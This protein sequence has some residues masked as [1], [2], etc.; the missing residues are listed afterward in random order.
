MARVVKV[1]NHDDRESRVKELNDSVRSD[2]SR[3]AG[4]KNTFSHL[5][6]VSSLGVAEPVGQEDD[7]P[8][9]ITGETLSTEGSSKMV[10]ENEEQVIN[11]SKVC[12]MASSS[13]SGSHV[14][15]TWA[16]QRYEKTGV[17]SPLR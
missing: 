6:K 8:M 3:S 12:K 14:G 11:D 16:R 4:H 9:E 1:I 13:R 7:D 10:G 17:L 5:C 2:V 15:R